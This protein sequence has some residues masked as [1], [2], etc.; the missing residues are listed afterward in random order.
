[1]FAHALSMRRWSA[2][3]RVV[4]GD[5]EEPDD[6]E[7]EADGERARRSAGASVHEPSPS[8]DERSRGPSPTPIG[9]HGPE[10]AD[11]EP[12]AAARSA[13]AAGVP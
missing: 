9:E 7:H 11:E 10:Q 6:H 8:D 13:A 2:I 4:V 5:H 3:D 12:R 1:M